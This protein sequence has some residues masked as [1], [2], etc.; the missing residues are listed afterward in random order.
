MLNEEVF[1]G[2]QSVQ[3]D[4]KPSLVQDVFSSVASK[5][6]IMNDIMSG[7]LHRLWKKT[8]LHEIDEY[9]KDLIDV[10]SGTGDIARAFYRKSTKHGKIVACDPNQ[11]MLD[12]SKEKSINA[13]MVDIDYVVAF[14]ESLPFE[15]NSFDYYT[16]AFGIRNFTDILQGL[17]EAYRI[18]KPGGKFLCLEFSYIENPFL[19]KLYNLYSEF[20]IPNMGHI[21]ANDKDS[22]KYL[23][24]SI[25]N[26]PQQEDFKKMI[27]QA[28][29][30]YVSYS[31]MTF[32]TVAIHRGIKCS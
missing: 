10:A 11:S 2:S 4:A 5:Y 16:I 27:E 7:G 14:G 8:F 28:G 15:N 25:K 9:S 23:V 24:D 19:R 29:F 6:D 13:G 26:F 32:G 22:Y 21:I 3:R 31:N 1:F 17:K 20:I 30:K 12:I 18:L